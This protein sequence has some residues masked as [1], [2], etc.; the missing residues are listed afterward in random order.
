MPLRNIVNEEEPKSSKTDK[1]STEKERCLYAKC[2]KYM[3]NVCKLH[4]RLK[5]LKSKTILNVLSEE[6]SVRKLTK[7]ITPTFALLLQAQIRNFRKKATGR[8]WSN[9]EKIIALRL[10]KKSPTCYRLLRRL[11][12][13]PTPV[14]LKALLNKVPF[15]VGI[16][17]PVF[18]LL[19]HYITTQQP[20][21]N[22]FILMFDEM[23]LKKHL[24]YNLKEDIIEGYQD[25]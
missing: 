12:Q 10:Y 7:K 3:H 25:H 2:I 14:T 18:K 8:K 20:S 9:E 4:K 5:R 11:F 17:Q 16:S 15:A 23:S 21:D 24:D 22:E 13:L 1:L 6:N 19:A